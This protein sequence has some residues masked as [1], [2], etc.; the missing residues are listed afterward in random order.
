MLVLNEDETAHALGWANLIGALKDMFACDCRMPVRHHHTVEVPGRAD[1]TLLLMP[2][3]LPGKYCGVKLV[4]V[5][6][7]NHLSGLPAVQ[8]GYLLTSGETGAML[9][10]I[11]GGVL[12]ARRTAAAS[13]LAAS[14]LARK[15]ASHLL[16]VGTGRLSLHLIEAHA[17]IRPLT[18]ISIWGR[19]S[20]K[21]E[22]TAAAARALGFSAQAVT[23]IEEV[24]RQADIISCA[25]LSTDP[26]IKGDWLKPGAHVDLV[27]GFR[28]V[29]READDTAIRRARVYV[30]TRAGAMAEAGDIVQ[31]LRNGSLTAEQI[32]G[33]LTELVKGT[34][35]GRKSAEEITLFK[36]VGAALED[37]AGAILAYETVKARQGRL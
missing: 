33:E 14:Y 24:A 11:D 35:D 22:E 12:T 20:A 36:S 4:S 34:V 31:P 8:G 30:D 26:L 13:A 1:A 29:M 3:W 15:D 17:S 37:L 10:L 2:A 6:P 16:M 25:T 9:A 28:P 7:D 18:Q 21:A 23:E 27:G 32:Q 19:N 5:F